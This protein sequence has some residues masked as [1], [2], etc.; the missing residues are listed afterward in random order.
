MTRVVILGAGV[1]GTAFGLPLSDRGMEVRLVG[2]HLDRD[3]VAAMKETRVHPR[4]KAE[5]GANITVYQDSEMA[6]AFAEPADLIIGAISTPG[7][8]WAIERFAEHLRGTPPIVLLTKGISRETEKVEILPDLVAREFARMGIAHGPLGAIGGPCI[9]GELAVRHQT[10]ALIGFRDIALARHWAEAIA[11]PY[12]HLRAT[13]DLVGLEICAAL[14][15]FYAI[16][17]ST[18]AGHAEIAP[19]VNGAGQNN[20]VASL[21]N[22][23]IAELRAIVAASGGVEETA[24][25][26]AGLGDLHVTCQ[27]GRNSRLGRLIGKGVSYREAMDGPLKGETVEGTLVA[28]ALAAPLAAYAAAGKLPEAAVPLARAIIACVT[29]NAGFKMDLDPYHRG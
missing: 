3:L 23:A 12:Y 25:G 9:A 15:N 6:E 14:K 20:A 21:F 10:S 7:I 4:L 11:T 19:A 27:A 29:A 17:V 18:P 26:L 13:D 24:L 22:Q 28:E 1:M 2:T 16:G 8:E 5:I